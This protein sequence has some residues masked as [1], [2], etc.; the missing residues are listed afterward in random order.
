MNT[1]NIEIRETTVKT[2]SVEAS[3]MDEAQSIFDGMDAIEIDEN[4]LY[5]PDTEI[6]VISIEEA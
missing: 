1:Y 4:L 2:V 6:E 5:S 3:N